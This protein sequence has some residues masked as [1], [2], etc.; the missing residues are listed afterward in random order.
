MFLLESAE[1]V[2]EQTG[3]LLL[4]REQRQAELEA[5]KTVADA[6]ALATAAEQ[7]QG[8]AGVAVEGLPQ[9]EL[10]DVY[11]PAGE[12]EGWPRFESGQGKHL[13]R[14]IEYGDWCLGEAFDPDAKAPDACI[15]GCFHY[16]LYY[17]WP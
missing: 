10:N 14:D 1:E 7:L 6:A 13:Y 8:V 11:L 16:C 12:H 9:P 3:R 5:E 4:L 15:S 2:A 17:G